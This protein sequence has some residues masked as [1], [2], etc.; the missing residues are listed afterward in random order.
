M[1]DVFDFIAEKG[2]N[3]M[4]VKESQRRRYASEGAVEE[5]QSLY[6]DT[7]SSTSVS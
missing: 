4:K 3:P 7:R 1:L 2:G 6:E 5:V